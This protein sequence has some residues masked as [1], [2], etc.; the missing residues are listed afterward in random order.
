MAWTHAKPETIE[1]G[2]GGSPLLGARVMPTLGE[3]VVNMC[4]QIPEQFCFFSY[5]TC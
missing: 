1:A 2:L 4:I 5:K 3:Y